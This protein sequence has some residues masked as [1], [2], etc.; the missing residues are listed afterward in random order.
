MWL[1]VTQPDLA[2]RSL[3]KYAD[4]PILLNS[5][6]V[7]P[8]RICRIQLLIRRRLATNDWM[9]WWCRSTYY[10]VLWYKD[11]HHEIT[12]L[13]KVK[14]SLQPKSKQKQ[15]TKTKLPCERKVKQ[16]Q[17]PWERKVRVVYNAFWKEIT[18]KNLE[19]CIWYI[20]SSA[21]SIQNSH[22]LIWYRYRSA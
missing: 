22:W 11:V 15:K 9:S 1:Q 13:I 4:W 6:A 2:P 16:K 14:C 10:S 3:Q 20:T 17:L 5:F 7:N 21:E 18:N 12:S 19:K 8:I